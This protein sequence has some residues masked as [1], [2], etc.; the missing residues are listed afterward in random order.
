MRV[1]IRTQIDGKT[2]GNKDTDVRWTRNSNARGDRNRSGDVEREMRRSARSLWC[3][4][5]M[6][7][8]YRRTRVHYYEAENARGESRFDH[9][10]PSCI[11]NFNRATRVWKT[12]VHSVLLH[13]KR[14][15]TWPSWCTADWL[16]LAYDLV[17]SFRMISFSVLGHWCH[18]SFLIKFNYWWSF[19]LNLYFMD[20][21]MSK[22]LVE[23][24][25]RS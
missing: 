9:K 19:S 7:I 24:L 6:Y 17:G 3:I 16:R 1:Y 21:K 25:T 13:N 5:R 14:E 8:A 18:S 10:L 2:M 23:M 4:Y 12:L 15:S 11:G 20:F 22:F